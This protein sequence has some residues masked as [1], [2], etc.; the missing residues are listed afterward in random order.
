MA[1]LFLPL[2]HTADDLNHAITPVTGSDPIQPSSYL[3]VTAL[4]G[5]G[6]VSCGRHGVATG[7]TLHMPWR[8]SVPIVHPLSQIGEGK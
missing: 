8:D 5:S 1:F 4:R 6:H 3:R 7:D 2:R